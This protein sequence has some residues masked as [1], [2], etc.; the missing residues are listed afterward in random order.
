MTAIF[1]D[2]DSGLLTEYL[3]H[4]ETINGPLY[5]LLIDCLRPVILE[6]RCGNV[7]SRVL[8]FHENALVHKC[9]IL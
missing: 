4:E 3:I 6:K 9:H 7:K 2:K 8:L 1:L 5:A